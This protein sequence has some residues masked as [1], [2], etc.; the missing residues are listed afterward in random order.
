MPAHGNPNQTRKA[1]R[2]LAALN[3]ICQGYHFW[4]SMFMGNKNHRGGD[5]R[6]FLNKEG[7]LGEVEVRALERK[8]SLQLNQLMTGHDLT[9]MQMAL[10]MKTSRA[11][12]DRLLDASNPSFTLK[13]LVK[14]AS[15]L[16]CKVKIEL[17]TA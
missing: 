16:G 13:T 12:V 3:L 7:I 5:F 14:A 4:H 2:P 9:K 6:G 17:V 1:N 11:T 15:A 8:L 10:R